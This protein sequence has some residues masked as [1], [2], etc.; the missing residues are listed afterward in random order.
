M[1]LKINKKMEILKNHRIDFNPS[2]YGFFKSKEINQKGCT[3]KVLILGRFFHD[4]P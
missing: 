4:T 2:N 1:V 3:Q